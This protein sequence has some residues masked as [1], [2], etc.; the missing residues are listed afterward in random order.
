MKKSIITVSIIA[1][2]TANPGLSIQ[3]VIAACPDFKPGTIRSAIT[4]AER[5][6]EIRATGEKTTKKFYLPITAGSAIDHFRKQ[7]I[8]CAA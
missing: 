2:V 7:W 3:D 5:K 1:A 6:C 8:G 4:N